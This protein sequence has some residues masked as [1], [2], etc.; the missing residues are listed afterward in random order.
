MGFSRQEHCNGLPFPPPGD[1]PY[2]WIVPV[3]LK[4]PV[5]ALAGRFFPTGATL[6]GSCQFSIPSHGSKAGPA[7]SA[8]LTHPCPS[9]PKS[10]GGDFL[11]TQLH[12]GSGEGAPA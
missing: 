3:S 1:L 11:P 7:P 8:S 4:S 10:D 2:L 5:L 12:D 9:R 6:T